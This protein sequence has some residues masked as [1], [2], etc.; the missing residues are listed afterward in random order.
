MNRRRFLVALVSA[1][2]LFGF[3]KKAVRAGEP[4]R[5]N[6][7]WPELPDGCSSLLRREAHPDGK[8]FSLSLIARRKSADRAASNLKKWG[9]RPDVTK[10]R[11]I[12]LEG[13]T[14]RV[15]P[16]SCKI[17]E[18]LYVNDRDVIHWE[19]VMVRLDR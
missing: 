14:Y 10:G 7:I 5:A 8:S 16:T 9:Q 11:V 15:T 18:G 17:N 13:V 1:S 4:E 3:G 6:L 19:A 12:Q 2:S